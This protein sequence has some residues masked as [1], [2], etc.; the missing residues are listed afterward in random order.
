MRLARRDAGHP[1]GLP[2]CRTGR[3]AVGAVYAV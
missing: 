3:I 1:W 2:S